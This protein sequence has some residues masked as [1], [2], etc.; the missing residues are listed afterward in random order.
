MSVGWQLTI[1]VKEAGNACSS[2]SNVHRH[3]P[4]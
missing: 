4:D 3:A 2:S 1:T